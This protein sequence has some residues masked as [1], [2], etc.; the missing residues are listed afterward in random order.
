MV[1]VVQDIFLKKLKSRKISWPARKA[2][3]LGTI[4]HWLLDSGGARAWAGEAAPCKMRQVRKAGAGLG[5]FLEKVRFE[6][7]FERGEGASWR[8]R[9]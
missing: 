8:R 9:G 4:Q 1:G 3:V 2:C 5:W 7:R 6:Q